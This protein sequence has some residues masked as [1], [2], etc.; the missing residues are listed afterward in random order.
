MRRNKNTNNVSKAKS[1]KR[2]TRKYTQ[3]NWITEFSLALII[4][5][6]SNLA[7]QELLSLEPLFLIY[8]GPIEIILKINL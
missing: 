5:I 8:I 2:K 7:V 6:I 4:G 1:R 3:N